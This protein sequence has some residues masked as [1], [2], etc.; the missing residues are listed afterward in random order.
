VQ[1]PSSQ[2]HQNLHSTAAPRSAALLSCVCLIFQHSN[3]FLKMCTTNQVIY[4][5]SH[6]ATHRFRTGVCRNATHGRCTIHD[7]TEV[8]SY[9]CIDCAALVSKKRRRSGDGRDRPCEM[10][11]PPSKRLLSAT[12]HVPSRCFVDV[13]FQTLDPFS[14]GLHNEE[15][16]ET[17]VRPLRAEI[18]PFGMHMELV[19]SRSS[20]QVEQHGRWRLARS[21]EKWPLS[22]CCQMETS[23]GAYES[24]RLE[25]PGE[26]VNGRIVDSFCVSSI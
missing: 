19:A 20:V 26:R 9:P 12:W 1:K 8:L 24:T 10:Q 11:G 14:V 17:L 13:G 5:C 6:R 22:Q 16:A 15:P 25:G 7:E 3:P 23:Y 21:N 18:S 4:I 2:L